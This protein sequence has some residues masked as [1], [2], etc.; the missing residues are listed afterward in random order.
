MGY[1]VLKYLA[2]DKEILALDEQQS[3][4]SIVFNYLGQFDN[5]G[6]DA[7]HFPFAEES[8]GDQVTPQKIERQLL[9]LKGQ[10]IKSKLR[11]ILSYSSLHITQQDARELMQSFNANL[12]DCLVYCQTT[13]GKR[14]KLKFLKQLTINET[15]NNKQSR[16]SFEI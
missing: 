14:D 7:R 5:T 16:E 2:K 15:E 3:G 8:S 4:A 10:I 12:Q 11:F 1:G 9:S 13:L 6:D